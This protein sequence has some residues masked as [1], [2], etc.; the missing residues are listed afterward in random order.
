MSTPGS[1]GSAIQ[2]LVDEAVGLGVVLAAHV[3][4]RP[5]LEGSQRLLHLAMQLAH[6][7]VLDLVLAL[8]LADDQLGVADQLELLAPSAAAARSPAAAP[9][10]RRRCWSPGRSAR[11]C[12]SSTSPPASWTTAA[13]A[14]GPGVA[15]GAAVDVDDEL[16]AHSA[17]A[18]RASRLP[19][20]RRGE[21]PALATRAF[22]CRAEPS[23]W[24]ISS[25]LPI[26]KTGRELVAEVD[27]PL[28]PAELPGDRDPH[29]ARASRRRRRSRPAARQGS[30][31]ARRPSRRLRSA[32]KRST[33]S[34]EAA[35]PAL[36][37]GLSH[38]LKRSRRPATALTLAP[39][40]ATSATDPF[41][42]R[43][44]GTSS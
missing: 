21:P 27:A 37:P 35:A 32:L 40:Y 39:A 14:A 28:V 8:H 34:L 38:R 6:R 18:L 33:A 13:I 42:A 26:S 12:S 30:A 22:Q 24:S 15:P 43:C 9:C 10:T 3:A 11:R 7:R 44:A 31:S 25:P 1:I 17:A 4:D 36:A 5:A 41:G 16:H 2:R 23:S 29:L 20:G 19:A